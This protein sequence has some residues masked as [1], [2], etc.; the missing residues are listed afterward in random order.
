MDNKQVAATLTGIALKDTQLSIS[1]IDIAPMIQE[2]QR[3]SAKQM[4][5][6]T[7]N[8][9]MKYYYLFLKKLNESNK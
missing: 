4:D 5:E 1:R 6:N 7:V 3:E 2:R 8:L 9:V